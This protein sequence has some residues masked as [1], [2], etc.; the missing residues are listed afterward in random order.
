MGWFDRFRSPRR[1]PITRGEAARVGATMQFGRT[2]QCRCGAVIRIRARVDRADG[3]S[4]FAAYP[5][6]HRLAGHSRIPSDLLSWA[7][8]LEERG[9]KSQPVTCP[10]C[11]AGLSVEKF[12]AMRRA[13]P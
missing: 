10:A 6:G 8:M 1:V 12:K 13:Q 2:W 7:G 11:Q 9:W 3:P 5:P 4:N